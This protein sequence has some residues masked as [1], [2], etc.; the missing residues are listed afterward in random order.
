M[1]SSDKLAIHELLSRAAYC[2][3]ERKLDVLRQCFTVDASML[4]DT[5]V[6]VECQQFYHSEGPV[7]LRPVG[8][9]EF[10][11]QFAGPLN[12]GSGGTQVAAGIVGFAD[13]TL[14]PEVQA[15]L[16]AHLG[17]SERFQGIRHASAW[18]AFKRLSA[19]YSVSERTALFHDTASRVYRLQDS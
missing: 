18:D 8:E 5:T 4:V 15:V 19:D 11:D 6:F 2:F 12:T 16:E 10:V 1:K 13:L 14:G 3:D 17:V 9:T 7:E